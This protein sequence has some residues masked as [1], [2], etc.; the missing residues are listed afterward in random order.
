MIVYFDLD[1]T[2]FQTGRASEIW[3]VLGRLYPSIQAAQ[4]YQDRPAYYRYVGDQY[5]HDLSAQLTGLG[6]DPA[7]VYEALCHTELAD[8]RFEFEYCAELIELVS[9]RAD[10]RIL[11]FGSDDYQRFKLS[12]CP[13]LCELPVI[14][15]LRAKA[16]VLEDMQG[17]CWLVDDKSIGDELP[18]NVSFVQVSLEGSAVPPHD[19]WPVFRDLQKVREFFNEVL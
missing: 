17:V 13:T 9:A 11:T 4:A 2:L 5:Y 3:E 18:G 6:L 1:R 12:L 8:G 10:A 7:A 19:I 16:E 15:T 14:T